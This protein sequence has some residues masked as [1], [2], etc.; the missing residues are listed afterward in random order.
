MGNSLKTT[1]LFLA[2]TLVLLALGPGSSLGQEVRRLFPDRSLIPALLA[3]PRDPMSS[4][5]PLLV[6]QNPNAHGEGA[7]VEVSIGTSIPVFL[8]PGKS[9]KRRLVVGIEAAA[10]ARFGLQVLERELIATDWV[11]AV[12][13]VLH[14]D[15]SWFRFRYYHTSSHM[16]D[17]YARRFDEPGINF[18]R[19]AAEILS[20]HSITDRLGI[21]GG[22]RYA[23]IVHPEESKRWVLRGGA[24]VEAQEKGRRFRPFMATDLEWDQDAGG[25]RIEW[26]GGAWLPTV[27]GRR[28]L[29]LAV[30]VLAGPSPLGQFNGLSTTQVGITLRGS[31]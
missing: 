22:A 14:R 1:A 31:L 28:A 21:Y 20:Y 11:F 10:F 4:F 18:A 17:E 24:Q 23:Y 16:G 9:G 30:V 19:D 12:P 7:E 13:I 25:T 2:S 3:G 27:G 26:Q 29:R 6:S 15:G 8:F 5:S